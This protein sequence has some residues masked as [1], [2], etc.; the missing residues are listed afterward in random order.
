LKIEGTE[1][2]LSST[3]D[4][5]EGIDSIESIN[6]YKELI[7]KNGVFAVELIDVRYL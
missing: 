5:K 6:G 2:T 3:N 1:F 7:E 4:I